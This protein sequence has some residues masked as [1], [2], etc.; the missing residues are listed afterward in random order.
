MRN[1]GEKTQTKPK[2]TPQKVTA[3]VVVQVQCQRHNEWS[4]GGQM[5]QEQAHTSPRQHL[6]LGIAAL[7][8]CF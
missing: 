1:R 2:T 6:G 8:L 3:K 5:S 4:L 7:D